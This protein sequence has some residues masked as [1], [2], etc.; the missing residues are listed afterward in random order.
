LQRWRHL[1]KGRDRCLLLAGLIN[2]VDARTRNGLGSLPAL[3]RLAQ[4]SLRL[5]GPSGIIGIFHIPKDFI[6]DYN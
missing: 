4:E 6:A 5:Q 1:L 2:I 3:C